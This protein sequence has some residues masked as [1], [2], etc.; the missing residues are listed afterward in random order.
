MFNDASEAA[1]RLDQRSLIVTSRTDRMTHPASS[2]PLRPS[3]DGSEL[4]ER[5][6]GSD[7]DILLPNRELFAAIRK[8]V[9]A[10]AGTAN[11]GRDA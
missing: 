11:H 4:S 8:F 9:D 10:R 5:S 2:D 3:V 1:R 7:H 6:T